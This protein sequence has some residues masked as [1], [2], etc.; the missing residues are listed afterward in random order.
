MSS[1]DLLVVA[2]RKW[3]ETLRRLASEDFIRQNRETGL[4]MPQLGA[5][6]RLHH[7]A[8]SVSA[9]G[10]EMG[11][12]SAAA[13]QMLDRL[14]QQGLISR[15]ENPSDRRVKRIVLTDK[16]RQVLHKSFETRQQWMNNLALTL[17]A[18]EKEQVT[19]ALNIL[20]DKAQQLIEDTGPKPEH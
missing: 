7:G 18:S 9:L 12:T 11:V 13:S 8:G 20:I 6:L 14:V 16:G 17:S 1:T 10:E 19:A 4:S 3:M 5:M 15:S 2:L